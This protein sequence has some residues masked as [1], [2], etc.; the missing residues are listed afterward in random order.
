[1]GSASERHYQ[2]R[3]G[4]PVELKNKVFHFQNKVFHFQNNVG[5]LGVVGV[6]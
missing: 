6:S 4:Y 2:S 1:M 3:C 5:D